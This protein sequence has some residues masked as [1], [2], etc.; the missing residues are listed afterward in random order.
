MQQGYI[1]LN[2]S[3]SDWGWYKNI[4]VK[5]TFIHLLLNAFFSDCEV[6]GVPIK[7]GQIVSGR[8]IIAK[9]TGLSEQ[10]VRTALRKLVGAGELRIQS[11]R[12][13]SI[14]TVCNYDTYIDDQPTA[15]QRLTN[16][17]PT[18]NQQLTNNQPHNN[19]DNNDKNEKNDNTVKDKTTNVVLKKNK[20]LDEREKDFAESLKPYLDKYGRDMLNDFF[21]Y[22]T[23]H[24]DGG[25]KMRF[26]MQKTFSIER[27][28]ST[29]KRNDD[30]SRKPRYSTEQT[31]KLGENE[32]IDTLSD[33]TRRRT[34]GT[35]R[36]TIPF[37]APPRPSSQFAWN[38]NTG[39][40]DINM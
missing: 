3:F 10:E 24:N 21:S 16:N 30:K 1:K 17:Q 8:R 13:Y 26:E 32:W 5:V 23:E 22:W 20:T 25:R 9:E 39:Q 18:A 38:P 6:E 31:S 35:G 28:L 29:W 2:R 7:R 33:G 34:Y 14:I 27:R 19:N 12:S 37:D 4:P 36:M 11:N 40:W 15:N